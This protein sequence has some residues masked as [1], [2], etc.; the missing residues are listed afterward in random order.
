MRAIQDAVCERF[1]LT[2]IELLAHRRWRMIVRARQVGMYLAKELTPRSY[3]H[4]A[5]SFGLNDHTTVYHALRM[6][7]RLIAEGDPIAADVEAI[8][9]KLVVPA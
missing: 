2:L 4:I 8:R 9:S 6:I 1:G 3:P 7:E 5:N